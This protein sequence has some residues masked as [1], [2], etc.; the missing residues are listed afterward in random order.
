MRSASVIVV[1]SLTLTLCT[2]ALAND[3]DLRID[4]RAPP[5]QQPRLTVIINKDVE[6]VSIDVAAGKTRLRQKKGPAPQGGSIEFTL[7]QSGFGKVSW[8]GNLS[9]VFADGASGTLPLAFQ[10]E[11]LSTHFEFYIR[12]ENLDLE[13]DKLTLISQ[14]HTSKV[15]IEVYTDED[16]LLSSSSTDY[17]TVIPAGQLVEVSWLPKK[18]AD[19]LRLRLTVYDENGSF[20]ISDSFPY[21]VSIEHDDVVF[22]SGKSLIRADQEPKLHAVVPAIDR[23][24]KRF[25]PAMTAAGTTVKLFVQG[26][27]DSV[28]DPGANR[29]LSQ[30]R[31]LAIAT[32]FKQHGVVVVVYARGFGEDRLKVET[33]DHTDQEQNR[34]AEYEVGVDSPTLSLAGWTLVKG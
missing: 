6:S 18:K 17:A 31:A 5:G 13:H 25:G 29:V 11:R 28:G 16:E 23:A 27:T 3:V 10:T 1:A 14:R 22:D 34:R 33:P 15:D 20:Q 32:W 4:A 24:L 30:Q 8:K 19:V 26:H 21:S 12:K 9:V 2:R 7:P